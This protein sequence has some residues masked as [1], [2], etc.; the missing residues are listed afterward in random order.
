MNNL[1][2]KINQ[3]RYDKLSDLEVI[4]YTLLLIQCNTASN[5]R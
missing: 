3:I 5:M 4:P 2:A 1:F